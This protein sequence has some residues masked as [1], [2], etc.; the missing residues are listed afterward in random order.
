MNSE[1]FIAIND[2]DIKLLQESLKFYS[3]KYP[4]I[5]DEQINS[6]LR[7]LYSLRVYLN[8]SQNKEL[9]ISKL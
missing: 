1:N 5:D 7:K 6:T 2:S 3:Q 4:V 9:Y 8:K